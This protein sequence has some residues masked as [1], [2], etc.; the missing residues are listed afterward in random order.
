M[1]LVALLLSNQCVGAGRQQEW[2]GCGT[3]FQPVTWMSGFTNCEDNV[4]EDNTANESLEYSR[5]IYEETLSWY[6]S[7]EAKAQILLTLAGAF[8]A[9]L[10][11]IIVSKQ[12]EVESLLKSFGRD[13][14]FYIA[15]M[16]SFIV[17]SI[18]SALMCLRSRMPRGDSRKDPKTSAAYMWFFGEL[19]YQKQQEIEEFLLKATDKEEVKALAAQIAPFSYNV[20]AKHRWVNRGFTFLIAA[21]LFFVLVS[22]SFFLRLSKAINNWTD[23]ELWWSLVPLPFVPVIVLLLYLLFVK[24]EHQ[25]RP[26]KEP[27]HSFGTKGE[28]MNEAIR[29]IDLGAEFWTREKC[30]IIELSNTPDDPE[31]SIARARVNPGDTT[32]WHR[33][34]GT[35]ERYVILEGRGRVEVGNL[36]PQEVGAGDV[37]LIPPSCRQRITNIGEGDLI[38]LAICTPRFR[39]EAYEDIDSDPLQTNNTAETN[40]VT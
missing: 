11:S 31:A 17:A 13:T 16:A 37:V 1:G 35:G 7:A 6:R 3:P 22:A 32:R 12:A 24:A 39:R 30:H 21:L 2:P 26:T 25:E 28:T 36:P 5:R 33:V 9:F 34:V 4:A 38:F 19:R 15:I 18:F 10:S 40:A 8:V 27:S 29:R 14:Y 20:T 23:E